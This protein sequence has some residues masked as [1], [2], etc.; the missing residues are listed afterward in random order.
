MQAPY[1]CLGGECPIPFRGIR[2]YDHCH[3]SLAITEVAFRGEN[4]T[5]GCQGNKNGTIFWFINETLYDF[6]SAVS[7]GEKGI[8]IEEDEIANQTIRVQTSSLS[9]SVV[10]LNCMV[11]DIN[12]M[13]SHYSGLNA[14]LVIVGKKLTIRRPGNEA[15]IISGWSS[16]IGSIK[17]L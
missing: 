9:D 8:Q 17:F 15:T 5:F 4:L 13:S 1:Q 12:N 6:R 3:S 14:S 7:F 2:N 11:V 16:S 10:N